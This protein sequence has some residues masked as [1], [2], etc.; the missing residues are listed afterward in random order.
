MPAY[1]LTIAP[2]VHVDSFHLAE[3]D[4][5]NSRRARANLAWSVRKQTLRGGRSDGVERIILDNGALSVDIL[6]TRGMG[7][8]RGSYRGHHLGWASPVRGGPIHP[9]FVRLEDR[10]GLGWLGGFD[11]LMVRCGL[12]HNGPPFETFDPPG[13]DQSARRTMHPLHGRIANSP[14]HAVGVQVD[15]GDGTDPRVCTACHKERLGT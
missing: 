3:S 2:D 9:Q 1:P 15:D 10:G 5:P 13:G 14:E 7:I 6:P 4:L 12:A 8:W 11:E